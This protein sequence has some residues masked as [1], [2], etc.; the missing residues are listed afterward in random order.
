MSIKCMWSYE[1]CGIYIV[2]KSVQQRCKQPTASGEDNWPGNAVP[3]LR[4]SCIFL[5]IVLLLLYFHSYATYIF[6]LNVPLKL[7]LD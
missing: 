7:Q 5:Q 1:L 6:E 2:F 3:K 4:K